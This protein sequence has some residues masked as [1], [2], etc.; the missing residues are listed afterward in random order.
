M[1]TF[2]QSSVIPAKQPRAAGPARSAGRGI[3]LLLAMVFL[4]LMAA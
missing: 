1:P 4:P 3:A 2:I